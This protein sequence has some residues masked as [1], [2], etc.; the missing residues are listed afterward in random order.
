[1]RSYILGYYVP[2]DH[3]L[4]TLANEQRREM[5][6]A[7]LN[8]H[9]VPMKIKDIASKGKVFLKTVYGESYLR[10]MKED[11]FIREVDEKE[12]TG[13]PNRYVFENVNS[14]TR[15][16]DPKYYLAPGNV[17][18]DEG[19]KSA[20]DRLIVQTEVKTK[21]RTFLEF[22]KYIVES[23][24]V[25]DEQQIAPK[26]DSN[27]VCS[28]C[29]L[30]HEARDFIRATLLYLLD[31]FERSP[32]YLEFL[33]QRNYIDPKHYNE[34]CGFVE[35]N[36]GQQISEGLVPVPHFTHSKSN[37]V[38]IVAEKLVQKDVVTEGQSVSSERSEEEIL[39]KY[40]Y[41]NREGLTK[42]LIDYI[43]DK[44]GIPMV[45][46]KKLADSRMSGRSYLDAIYKTG[47]EEL[48]VSYSDDLVVR[49]DKRKKAEA[50][51]NKVRDNTVERRKKLRDKKRK[52]AQS[53]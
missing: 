44:T 34:Y 7:L 23:V 28:I 50:Y 22:V 48:G 3:L 1:M 14:L 12:E 38:H 2:S 16:R 42:D 11:G 5:Y 24:K 6:K 45:K 53:V 46:L 32:D 51:E 10:R 19:F 47:K 40:W 30:N 20:L 17:E 26:E 39:A 4:E 18:Y 49:H 52:A 37:D 43:L 13:G 35:T 27:Y 33:K 8:S 25:S 36:L 15:G 41:E 21:F 31:R 29:G 9:P